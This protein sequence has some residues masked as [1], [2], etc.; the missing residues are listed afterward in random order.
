MRPLNPKIPNQPTSQ[1]P[2]QALLSHRRQPVLTL[3]A[4]RRTPRKRSDIKPPVMAEHDPKPP[5]KTEPDPKPPAPVVTAMP[6]TDPKPP[7]PVV[8]A[9]PKTD[10][11]PPT[12]AATTTPK[13]DTPK[14]EEVKA[15]SF[16]KDVVPILRSNC[17][18][19]HGA[20]KGNP[21]GD[22]DLT[23]IAK[24]KASPGNLLVVGKPEKATSI[25]AS[26][27]VICREAENPSQ[28]LMT[29]SFSKTGSCREPR[30][31][32]VLCGGEG[33]DQKIRPDECSQ[34]EVLAHF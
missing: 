7:A 26:P 5:T 20:G 33:E 28:A 6:K 22:V 27:S 31:V 11:K 29:C 18:N 15:V 2:K 21:K 4:T 30:N 3:P 14:K 24:I 25:P 10:P 17:L 8:A 34:D 13:T 12:P 32:A 19:C 16:K 9:V 1:L 23:T